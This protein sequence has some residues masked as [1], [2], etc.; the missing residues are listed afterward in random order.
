MIKRLL[1]IAT[2]AV[3]SM[4][5][6]AANLEGTWNVR[7][8]NN[9]KNNGAAEQSKFD[10]GSNLFFG[11]LGGTKTIQFKADG[12]FYGNDSVY[13]TYSY[14]GNQLILNRDAKLIKKFE[15]KMAA[16]ASTE[17]QKANIKENLQGYGSDTLN[18]SFTKSGNKALVENAQFPELMKMVPYSI[19]FTIDKQGTNGKNE[20]LNQGKTLI[21]KTY[22]MTLMGMIEMRFT[23]KNGGKGTCETS[24]FGQSKSEDITYTTANNK[25]TI[26]SQS[27]P[28]EGE[29]IFNQDGF[30]FLMQKDD[31]TI[32]IS[33]LEIK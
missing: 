19:A 29:Y 5:S 18:V 20:S 28:M 25:L 1:L 22:K 31:S 6:F 8:L 9:I 21:G 7:N 33:F 27:S 12:T 14:K 23:F 13:G 30:Y 3:A 24:V 17:E 32:A 15:D 11:I 10:L 4:G 2:M 26:K 16:L